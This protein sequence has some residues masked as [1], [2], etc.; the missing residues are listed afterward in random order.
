LWTREEEEEELQGDK[1]L[2]FSLFSLV[3]VSIG[4]VGI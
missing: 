4:I 2:N 1:D 3:K